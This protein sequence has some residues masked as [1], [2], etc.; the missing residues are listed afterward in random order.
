MS[1]VTWKSKRHE[2]IFDL[3]QKVLHF[4]GKQYALCTV[5]NEKLLQMYKAKNVFIPE[6]HYEDERLMYYCV[7][8]MVEGANEVGKKIYIDI[9]L[10]NDAL[11]TIGENI[12]NRSLGHRNDV[13]EIEIH[14][15]LS[16]K[17]LELVEYNG[18][19]YLGIFKQ[20][21]YFEIPAGSFHCT[22][23]IEDN[24]IVANIFGNAFW[25]DNY[26]IKPYCECKNVF[27]LGKNKDRFLFETEDGKEFILNKELSNLKETGC[28]DYA[29]IDINELTISQRYDVHAQDIFEL[30]EQMIG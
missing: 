2:V 10:Y 22:Y 3:E 25:E 6:P 14:Q 28:K 19:Q 4:D 11:G 29:D 17:V 12:Y 21:D 8:K 23:V 15:V 5:S 9:L 20:D 1:I 7:R 26:E 27:S 18:K 16:G 13:N 24:T 30:F